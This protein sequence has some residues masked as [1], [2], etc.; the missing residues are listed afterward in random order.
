MKPRIPRPN[1]E[2]WST[3]RRDTSLRRDS[4][5]RWSRL[6]E[7]MARDH[8]QVQLHYTKILKLSI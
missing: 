5:E 3:F 4:S 8:S 6:L 2:P 1:H 7:N